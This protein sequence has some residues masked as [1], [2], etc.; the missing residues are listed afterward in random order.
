MKNS[1]SGSRTQSVNR[2]S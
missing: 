1:V 2:I